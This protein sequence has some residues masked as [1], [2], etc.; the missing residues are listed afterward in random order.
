MQHTTETRQVREEE[1]GMKEGSLEGRK[2]EI[3]RKWEEERMGRVRWNWE[4]ATE[5]V[6]HG[7]SSES[8]G[9]GDNVELQWKTQ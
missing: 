8:A 7:I 5:D 3:E 2:V 1:Q 9:A 4:V 6:C